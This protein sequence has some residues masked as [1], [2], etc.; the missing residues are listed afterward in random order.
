MCCE[1]PPASRISSDS[2]FPHQAFS[3]TPRCP[4]TS[5]CRLLALVCAT[6]LWSTS[7]ASAQQ[8]AEWSGGVG[9]LHSR[10]YDA[11]VYGLTLRH[12]QQLRGA[13]VTRIIGSVNFLGDTIF[14][15]S[16]LTAGVDLGARGTLG[17]VSLHAAIGPTLAYFVR[18]NG[19]NVSCE[20]GCIDRRSWYTTGA[21]VAVTGALA[22]GYQVTPAV[23][24]FYEAR[25]H[26]PLR[27]G[28][29][30]YRGD[31]NAGFVEV[32]IGVALQERPE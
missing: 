13:I 3:L 26:V 17:P 24:M 5:P 7:T 25:G 27:I 21:R 18:S 10:P 15:P 32:A 4:L 8:P 22:L 9:F 2:G 16:L 19:S 28:R 30:G 11:R 12:E 29:A 6:L 1:G 20:N 14:R 23:R 31:P